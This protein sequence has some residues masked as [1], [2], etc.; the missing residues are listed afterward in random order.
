MDQVLVVR[1]K[2]LVEGR[3]ARQVAREHGLSRNT[4]RR[5]VAGAAVGERKPVVRARPVREVIA[6]KIEALLAE[7]AAWTQ[8][9]QQLTASRLWQ[10]LREQGHDVGKTLVKEHVAEWKRRRR[11]VFVPL[12]YRPGELAE[13]SRG[14]TSTRTRSA[15][16]TGTCAP[17][18]TSAASRSGSRT[19][20]SSSRCA[21]SSSVASG[22]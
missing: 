15:S 1:H 22:R 7:S 13:A 6:P 4:V 2:V 18:L 11:E 16:S 21:A 8:G 9:K 12:T 3:S 14:S 19:T 17:S 10:L 20:I 5:Y